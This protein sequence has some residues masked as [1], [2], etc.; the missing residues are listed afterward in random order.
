[1][2][3]SKFTVEGLDYDEILRCL[4]E[5]GVVIITNA[6]LHQECK[7]FAMDF[8]SR[9]QYALSHLQQPKPGQFKELIC[10]DPAL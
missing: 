5:Y 6:Y 2:K 7:E 8:T 9:N 10:N 3:Q 4:R 1:M